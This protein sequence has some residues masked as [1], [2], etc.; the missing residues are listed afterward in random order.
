MSKIK[1]KVL[2]SHNAFWGKKKIKNLI[3]NIFKKL[4]FIFLEKVNEFRTTRNYT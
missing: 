3:L 4:S 1:K 2:I